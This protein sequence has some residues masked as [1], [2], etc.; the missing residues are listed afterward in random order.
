M[1]H[2]LALMQ[3]EDASELQ[4]QLNMHMGSLVSS[5]QKHALQLQQLQQQ[6]AE[7]T[8]VHATAA[9]V[10]EGVICHEEGASLPADPFAQMGSHGQ[11]QGQQK[12]QQ[13]LQG[14]GP[15]PVN[16]AVTRASGASDVAGSSGSQIF[17][18]KQ[19][20]RAA[21][22]LLDVAEAGRY[23]TAAVAVGGLVGGQKADPVG[24]LDWIEQLHR[25]MLSLD[26]Q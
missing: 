7:P 15:Q 1:L 24:V 13:D 21:Q 12:R 17:E 18:V 9:A 2:L 16:E 20:M 25:L 14:R 8:A 5:L 23:E 6:H 22:V 4:E 26:V 10:A 3:P 11:K 19:L